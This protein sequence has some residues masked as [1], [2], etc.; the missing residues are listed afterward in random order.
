MECGNVDDWTRCD[1]CYR[2]AAHRHHVYFGRKN[3]QLSEKYNMIEMLC[4]SCHRLVHHDRECDLLLKRKHQRIFEEDHTREE[5]M[6]LFGRS[7][8]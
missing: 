6:R 4:P 3:R 5:F 8:L 1:I 7:Y 2:R